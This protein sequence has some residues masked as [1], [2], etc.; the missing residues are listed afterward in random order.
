[1]SKEEFRLELKLSLHNTTQKFNVMLKIV[2]DLYKKVGT[3]T[4]PINGDVI[5]ILINFIYFLVLHSSYYSYKLYMDTILEHICFYLIFFFE[6]HTRIKLSFYTSHVNIY[7]SMTHL[8]IF[9]LHVVFYK[10]LQYLITNLYSSPQL[11]F[12]TIMGAEFE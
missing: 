2:R 9:Y 12:T 10:T 1:M 7:V 8:D 4:F 3:F 6:Y 5:K 11:S